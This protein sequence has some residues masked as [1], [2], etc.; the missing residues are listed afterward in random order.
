M[1]GKKNKINKKKHQKTPKKHAT[2]GEIKCCISP[3]LEIHEM[4]TCAGVK[5]LVKD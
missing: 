1:C 2:A 5:Q 3:W 4:L